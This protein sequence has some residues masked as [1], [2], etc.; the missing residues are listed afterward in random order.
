MKTRF[1]MDKFPWITTGA[2]QYAT[3]WGDMTELYDFIH[4]E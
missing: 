4:E 3:P 1:T 2:N